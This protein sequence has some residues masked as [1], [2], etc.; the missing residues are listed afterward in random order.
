MSQIYN[1]YCDESCHLEN[2]KQKVMVLGSVWCQKEKVKEVSQRIK[3]IKERNRISNNFEIKWTKVSNGKITFYEDLINYFF[4]NDDLHFRA[5]IANKE[6]LD[7]KKLNST[8]DEWYYKMYFSM[9]KTILEPTEEYNI[10]IDIKDTLGEEK[11]TKLQEVLCN[12]FYDFSRNII[13]KIQPI[14]SNESSIVQITDLLIGSLAYLNRD[15]SS[16]QSKLRLIELIQKRSNYT[17]K[18]STL[19]RESKI[20]LFYWTGKE[21]L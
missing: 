4:D 20:N 6:K 17:L 13:K 14:R 19:Y 5:I 10:Y 16:S 21:D 11:R 7:H 12:S 2:D 1:L 15:L 3:E 8:H 9:I 18:Q